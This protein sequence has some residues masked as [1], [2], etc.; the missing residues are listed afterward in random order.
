M[1]IF[2]KHI[3][4]ILTCIVIMGCS[5]SKNDAIPNIDEVSTGEGFY[6]YNYQRDGFSKTMRVF[7]FIPENKTVNTPILITLHGTERNASDYRDALIE[8][9]NLK[10]FI[11]IA[12]EFSETNFPT[13]DGYNLGNVF[14][15]GDNPSLTT[16]NPIS[17]WTFSIIEPLF[18]NFK[19]KINNQVPKY[20]LFGHSAGAQF[21]HRLLLFV[22][23][24][25]VEKAVFSAAGWYTFPN[26]V[27]FPYGLS[28]STIENNNLSA[29]FER[30]I[31]VQ[32]GANDNNPNAAGLRHNEFADAQGFHRLERATNFYNFCEQ[33]AEDLNHNFNW[34]FQIIENTGHDFVKA[35]ENAVNFIFN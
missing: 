25:N 19:S 15:D 2:S 3:F 23:N 31:L 32:V 16:L 8:E 20:Q 28:N 27:V 14:V 26:D 29:Y 24:V 30:P 6:F 33:R 1:Q 10:N 21:A 13:G 9:A 5:T 7:Y 17:E 11:V 18:S 35:S 4:K 34:E 12:P 22:P